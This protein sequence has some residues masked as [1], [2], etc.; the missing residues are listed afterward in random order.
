MTGKL[1]L[2]RDI[3]AA[4]ISR[5]RL[6][7][8]VDREV[9]ARLSRGVYTSGDRRPAKL[10][11][12]FVRLPEGV[13]LGYESAA[14]VYGFGGPGPIDDP[15]HVIVPAGTVRPRILGVACHEAALPVTAPILIDGIPC[16]P[17][18]RCAIDLARRGS[19]RDGIAVLDASLRSGTCTADDLADELLLHDG[20]RGVCRVRELVP[21]A[22]GRAECVQES[23]LRLLLVDAGLQS[24]EPQV[25]VHDG[26]GRPAYRIDLAYR[27]RRIGLEYDGR[28][29]LAP[30]RLAADRS[31]MNWLSNRGWTMRHFTATD[32]YQYPT[33][34]VAEVRTL[35]E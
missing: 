20:L 3:V 18:A 11:A 1:H 15:V 34:T 33:V 7:T 23:H 4:N 29:H 2:Y 10:H 8:A 13:V 32:L 6:R 30:D 25:W 12:L 27:D 5:E 24:P 21:L 16:A 35:L 19:R 31:R 22:D 17:P 26:T 28:S 9:V 14:R